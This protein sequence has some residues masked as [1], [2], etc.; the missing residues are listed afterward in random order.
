MS[1]SIWVAVQFTMCSCKIHNV[2]LYVVQFSLCSCVI[3]W[4]YT[5]MT[6][7]HHDDQLSCRLT[8]MTTNHHYDQP[9]WR[10][11]IMMTNHHD[12]RPIIMTTTIMTITTSPINK[13][14]TT[15]MA[16]TNH[17][18]Q[19]PPPHI[20]SVILFIL[21]F[22]THFVILIFL[23]PFFFDNILFI[24]VFSYSF[25]YSQ[26]L[27]TGIICIL[28]LYTVIFLHILYTHFFSKCSN[29]LWL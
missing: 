20:R 7:N 29:F 24:L 11:T 2:P 10:P 3:P 21:I 28:T 19:L 25:F 23:H 16:T 1:S 22:Y 13:M 8:I 14:T 5:I 18:P 17:D 15:T 12:G 4:R 6:T 27:H 26:Y 9:S